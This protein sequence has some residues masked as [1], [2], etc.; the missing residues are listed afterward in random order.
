[1]SVVSR[2]IGSFA[3]DETNTKNPRTLR[4]LHQWL[5][6]RERKRRE[7]EREEREEKGRKEEEQR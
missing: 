3:V 7:E 6:K 2:Y 4:V 1:V 5:R